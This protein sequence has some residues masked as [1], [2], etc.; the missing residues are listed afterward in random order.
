MIV[1][2]KRIDIYVL[3]PAVAANGFFLRTFP[4]LSVL[5]TLNLLLP[6]ILLY[7]LYSRNVHEQEFELAVKNAQLIALRGQLN[8]HF[9][10]NVLESI[11]MHS[12]IKK[13]GET[14]Y[15]VECLALLLRQ[16][17]DWSSD[18]ITVGKELELVAAYL[19]LQK[20]RFGERLS[21]IIDADEGSAHYA[22]PRLFIVT[23]VENA[24]IHGIEP[25]AGKGHIFVRTYINDDGRQLAIE[26]DDSGVGMNEELSNGI[27]DNMRGSSIADLKKKSGIGI[28]S[29]CLR[30]RMLTNNK[31]D[32]DLESEEGVGTFIRIT[33][34]TE[35]LG[36]A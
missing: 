16:Y 29:T 15:M 6:S 26:I 10:F 36:H 32:F 21:F 34:P 25:K 31:A 24:C 13:E 22:I 14:A 35:V 5:L 19:K 7:V 17:V 9:L 12:L 23:F 28:V 4:I 20:H 8:A 3:E 27:L 1:A 33:M 11:R 30:I 18:T 2:D